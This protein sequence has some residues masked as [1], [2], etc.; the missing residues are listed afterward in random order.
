MTER[1]PTLK[2]RDIMRVLHSLGFTPIRQVGSHIFY[3]H[4]DGRT[5]LVSRHDREDVG[6]GLLRKILRDIEITPEEFSKYI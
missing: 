5:T 6:R 2:A 1:L 4:P 3:E